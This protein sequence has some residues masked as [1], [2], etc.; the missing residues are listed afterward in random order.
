MWIT[1]FEMNMIV[2]KCEFKL[3]SDQYRYRVKFCLLYILT[4]HAFFSFHI[5][6]IQFIFPDFC[7]KKDRLYQGKYERIGT[8]FPRGEYS[9]KPL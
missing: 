3:T 4:S 8:S 7:N 5:K 6:T 2:F 1:H 9:Q